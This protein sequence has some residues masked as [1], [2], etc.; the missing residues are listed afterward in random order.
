LAVVAAALALLA[1]VLIPCIPAAATPL[2]WTAGV[3]ALIAGVAGV[4]SFLCPK[5][6]GELLL[7]SAQ[8]LI[9]VGWGVLYFVVCCPALAIVGAGLLATGWG[10]MV[11]WRKQCGKS[12]CAVWKEIA[13]ILTGVVIPLIGYAKAIPVLS[14]CVNNP[15]A[16]ALGGLALFLLWGTKNCKA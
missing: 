6:C 14:V 13:Y 5:R 2:L 11:A 10:L 4:L 3:L 1:L 8:V 7:S 9:G 16:A 12:W 15:T